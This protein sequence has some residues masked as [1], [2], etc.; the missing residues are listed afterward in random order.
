MDTREPARYPRGMW[1]HVSL[2]QGKAAIRDWFRARH[3]RIDN[4]PLFPGILSNQIARIVRVWA[5]LPTSVRL[6]LSRHAPIAVHPYGRA[7]LAASRA[8]VQSIL[9]SARAQILRIPSLWFVVALFCLLTLELIP[10]SGRFLE[11]FDS[12]VFIGWLLQLVLLSL[13]VD[14]LRGVLPRELLFIPV[15]FYSSYYFALW[16]QNKHISVESEKLTAENP[17]NIID[18]DPSLYS[19]VTE[20]ADEFVASHYIPVAYAYESTNIDDQYVSYRLMKKDDLSKYSYKNNDG[21]QILRVYLGDKL[22]QNVGVLRLVEQPKGH[23]VSVEV[24]NDPGE[25]WK[26]WNIGTETTSLSLDNRV[27][28]SF[29]RAFVRKLLAIPFFAVGCKTSAGSSKRNCYTEFMTREIWINSQPSSVDVALYDSPVSVMLGIRRLSKEEIA[30]RISWNPPPQHPPGEDQ[31]FDALR[32]VVEGRSPALS[33]STSVL[34]SGDQIR[35]APFATGMAKRFLDLGRSD[36]AN[37][38]GRREQT[39]LLATGIA[40]LGRAEF[41]TV[42]NLLADLARKENVRDEYPLIYLRLADSGAQL[43]PIYRDQFLAQNATQTQKLFAVLA[44]CRMGQADSELISALKLEWAESGVTQP[45]NYRAA[46]FVALT[47]LGQEDELR[48]AA[49]SSSRVM[50]AWYDAVLAGRGK[51]DVGPNNCMPMEWPGDYT[52]V[53]PSMAPSLRWVEQQWR[54]AN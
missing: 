21:S 38:P 29:K 52:Y 54:V 49:Q 36:N 46:L 5:V 31:A 17:A 7:F 37:F 15:I 32:D 4:L 44:I 28:G 33:W 19:L 6:L 40:S 13:L 53:P 10:A 24:I 27:I 39:A 45:D 8:I 48:A 47:K 50:K 9:R 42:Q 23:I 14:A 12:F 20:R 16:A 18:F 43:Y 26:D 41:E 51:T 34:I 25:G 3:D 30:G 22:Q 1:N 11:Q 2:A 35:L